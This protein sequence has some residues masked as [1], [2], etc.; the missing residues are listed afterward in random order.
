[1]HP[2]SSSTLLNTPYISLSGVYITP[3]N[4]PF[5]KI[6]KDGEFPSGSMGPK[7]L[8]SIEFIEETGKEVI[9]TLPEKIMEAIDGKT[10]TTIVKN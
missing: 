9:I 2:L 10:G 1:M 7:I 6:Y 4:S 3:E 8:A 5:H